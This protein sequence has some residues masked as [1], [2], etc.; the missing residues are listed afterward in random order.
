MSH[1]AAAERKVDVNWAEL[2]LD[3]VVDFILIFVGLYAAMSVERCQADHAERD[4][5][6]AMLKDFGL[7]L[8]ANRA[9]ER[10]IEKDLGAIDEA[11]P[12]NNMGPMAKTF[13]DFFADLEHDDTLVHCL[14][15]EFLRAKHAVH[16]PACHAAYAKFRE[17]H[18]KVP[19][20]SSPQVGF[21]FR[22]AVL[23][24]FYRYEVWQMYL[25]GGVKVFKNKD[26][27]IKIGEVYNNAHLIERQVAEIEKTYNDVFMRQT[28]RSLATDA[29]LAEIIEDEE[30][31]GEL[32]TED[33]RQL[34]SV[35]EALKDERFAVLELQ[36]VL[37]LQVERL[38]TTVLAMRR[39]IE[40]AKAAIAEETAKLAK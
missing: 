17:E 35:D 14:H 6:V 27:A 37:V 31:E 15:E 22:P 4:E 29:E 16:T 19:G 8:D 33:R 5:Y 38:K 9:Q 2:A 32:S 11:T 40:V 18:K 21:A 30:E 23:T 12:P 36:G 26:V 24:P 20:A 28:G 25:A 3:K 39:E 7:E 13:T 1:E 34:V 10:S